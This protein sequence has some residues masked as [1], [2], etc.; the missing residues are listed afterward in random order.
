MWASR[1]GHASTAQMLIEEGANLENEIQQSQ[2]WTS[3]HRACLG[4]HR[5]TAEV[6]LNACQKLLTVKDERKKSEG[7]HTLRTPLLV[8]AGVGSHT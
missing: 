7:R 3:L 8:A 5:E 1:Y 6:V 4:G 2:G